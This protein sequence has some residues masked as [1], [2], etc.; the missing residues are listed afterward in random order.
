MKPLCSS[1]NETL[2]ALQISHQRRGWTMIST[3]RRASPF[4]ASTSRWS[5]AS[6]FSTMSWACC[7]RVRSSPV[8]TGTRTY[9]ELA[10]TTTIF[11]GPPSRG[12][13]FTA[14]ETR[15]PASSAFQ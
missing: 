7:A 13:D 8:F 3:L 6:A 14:S 2:T 4:R 9:L 5:D 11:E 1:Q 15:F 12:I 10:L